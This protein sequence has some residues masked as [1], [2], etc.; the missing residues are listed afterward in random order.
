M[1]RTILAAYADDLLRATRVDSI[2]A[3]ENYA[4]AEMSK[5][6]EWRGET[7]STLMRSSQKLC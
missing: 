1:T 2:R 6:D 4:K 5:I 7:R 3:V